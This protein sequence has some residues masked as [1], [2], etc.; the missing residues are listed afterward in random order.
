MRPVNF[1]LSVREKL[2]LSGKWP[3][4]DG[5]TWYLYYVCVQAN[6]T[7]LKQS[8]TTNIMSELNLLPKLQLIFAIDT[9]QFESQL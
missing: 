7:L 3:R 8:M 1:V 9:Q 5:E 2:S 4:K 6:L